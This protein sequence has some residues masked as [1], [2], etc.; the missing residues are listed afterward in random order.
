MGEERGV[1]VGLDAGEV[2]AVILHAGVIAHDDEAE[3]REEKREEEWTNRS[4]LSQE[5][6]SPIDRALKLVLK[7]IDIGAC[8]F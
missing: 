2:D 8:R 6:R 5:R 4:L 7:R 1:E 3:H